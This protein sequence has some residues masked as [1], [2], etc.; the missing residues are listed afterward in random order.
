MKLQIKL[1]YSLATAIATCWCAL[2]IS[3]DCLPA[4]K[5][6]Q[7]AWEK[8]MPDGRAAFDMRQYAA[9]DRFFS[10]A[11]LH[12][13]SA[14]IRDVY[15]AQG[16]GMPL[17]D[18]ARILRGYARRLRK[19]GSKDDAKASIP[20]RKRFWALHQAQVIWSSWTPSKRTARAA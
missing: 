2:V 19:L 4:Q 12:R 3:P 10:S 16:P 13:D 5:F 14:G 9:A 11:L 18:F 7:D 1:L 17:A 15:L 8:L 6:Q 20:E